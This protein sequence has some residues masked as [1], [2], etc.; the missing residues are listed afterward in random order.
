MSDE[1]K[2]E[3]SQ[4]AKNYIPILFNLYTAEE[5]EG[6]PDKLPLL[7]TIRMYLSL[8]K[9][10]VS[11]RNFKGSFSAKTA[12]TSIS[13][14]S[15]ACGRGCPVPLWLTRLGPVLLL[16]PMSCSGYFYWSQGYCFCC[17]IYCFVLQSKNVSG[18]VQGV[19]LLYVD[20]GWISGHLGMSHV[21]LLGESD[22]LCLYQLHPVP[23]RYCY[24]RLCPSY[25]SF[26][27]SGKSGELVMTAN[28]NTPDKNVIGCLFVVGCQVVFKGSWKVERRRERCEDKVS[29]FC[30]VY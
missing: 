16:V 24:L 26:W 4:Y 13:R 5:K 9:P 30:A 2:A 10:E 19:S 3:L 23:L 1:E 27:F 17:I 28:K 12:T 15:F 29:G 20:N 18:G 8:A 14:T 11:I 6:D 25:C 22:W 21:A 7:E